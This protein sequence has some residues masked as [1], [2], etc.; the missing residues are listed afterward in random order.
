M[1]SVATSPPG[2]WSSS[3]AI[4]APAKST[5]VKLIA[6]IERPTAGSIVER[7]EPR[8]P[9]RESALPYLRRNLGL[10]FQDQKLLFDRNALETCCCHWPS[11]APR[12]AKRPGAQ[13]A[14]DKVGLLERA[15]ANPIA[16]SGGE[17]Q[18]LAI[19]RAV[20]N[21][22]AILIADENRPPISTPNRRRGSSTSS[23]PSIRSASP[24]W[25][26]P[27][28]RNGRA[29]RQPRELRLAREPGRMNAWLN[30]HLLAVRDAVQ[31][32]SSAS[33]LGTLLA[34][35]VIAIALT[36]PAAG[37]LLV[38][39]VQR[40]AR[41]AAGIQQISLFMAPDADRKAVDEIS[42]ASRPI[43][44]VT[45]ASSREEALK[46]LQGRQPR[47]ATW[48]PACHAIRCLMPSSS[49]RPTPRRPPWNNWPSPLPTGP[50]SPC[51]ARRRWVKR[52]DAFVRIGRLVVSLLAGVFGAALCSP[53]S[54]P[55]VCRFWRMPPR[56][57]LPA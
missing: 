47:R 20:V 3:P 21:R 2:R 29:G 36:L 22:P 48:P 9:A 23:T 57:R 33:P 28:T 31:D 43:R 8:R 44:R 13:A 1:A 55:S 24:S 7:P 46:R 54:I 41:S 27:T 32:A 26:Q 40:T 25:S 6:A 37:W 35:C 30:Q 50:G 38:D 56:S 34:L 5:L 45:G 10:V 12:C 14:L 53:P 39:N 51:P 15:R 18:R 42:A 19:A 4:P 17:Q 49:N 11:S 16:L 52:F